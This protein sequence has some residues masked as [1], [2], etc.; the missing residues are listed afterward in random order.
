MTRIKLELS[1]DGTDFYG[2]ARQTGLR[3]VQGELERVLSKLTGESI[4]VFAS[5]RTDKGV[6]ARSQVVHWDQHQG[7]EAQRY[8][9][10]LQRVLPR[11]IVVLGAETVDDSFHARFSA[12]GKTYRYTIQTAA[13]TDIFTHRYVWH[14]PVP[15]DWVAMDACRHTLTG[16]HDFTSFCAATTP[17]EDKIRRI[18]DLHYTRRGTY[19]DIYCT[20]SGFLQHMV[21]IIVGTLVDVGLHKMAPSDVEKALLAQDRQTAGQTAPAQGLALWNV[22]YDKKS[23]DPYKDLA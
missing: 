8:P 6:H 11:D 9:W 15:L 23:L 1:Y 5:G 4:E 20:G 7:P 18:H 10:V 17:V 16:E 21:R 19:V 2:F 3:T 13:L 22:Y 12:C 14:Q